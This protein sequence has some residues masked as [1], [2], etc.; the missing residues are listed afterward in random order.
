MKRFAAL[1][2][3][4]ESTP[5]TGEKTAA[6][7]EYFR[8]APEP[9]RVWTIA[10]LSGRRPKRAVNAT[11]LRLWAAQAANVPLWLFEESYAVAGDL[12][13]TIAH[14]LPPAT[15]T[16]AP[17]LE[18]KVRALIALTGRAE[19]ERR[20]FVL[21]AWRTLGSDERFLFNKLLTGGFRM[22]VSRGLMTRAL[23]QATGVDNAVMAHRL[24]GD[25]DPAHTLFGDLTQDGG[26][27]TAARPYPFALASPLES[28]PD[29]LGEPDEYLAEWKWDGIRGQ[30]IARTGAFAIWS[31]GEDLITDRFPEFAPL[32][33]HLPPGTVLDGEIVAW[34]GTAP[35]PFADLQK[36]IGR[37][38]VPRKLLAE[39]P[40][41]F[42]AY[43]L[44]ED[45]G[46]DLRDAPLSHRRTRL[47]AV[48]T[49][50]PPG[51]P[52]SASPV[53]TGDWTQLANLRASA[54]AQMAEGLMLKRLAAPY[55]TGRK[56]GDWWKWKLDPFTVDAV[57][58]YAQ[59]GH[60]R[61]A[62]LFSDFTFALRD[63]NDLVP[64]TK[65][66][67]G[68]TDAEFAE[69]TRWVGK[70]TL[71][72]FGPVRRVTP[73]LV[74]EIGFEGIQASPRHKSGIALRFPRI[75]RWRRDKGVAEIDTLDGL[76]DLLRQVSEAGALPAEGLKTGALPPD[77]QDI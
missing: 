64:F 68:L 7:T 11:E 36:R 76:R 23:A 12:A 60:G 22:G 15:T 21:A 73:E 71:E 13:E 63:G 32:Q 77:P 1:F 69:I 50:L 5:K 2:T 30:I 74:F 4:L 57:M 20:E 47:E 62:N 9:D 18:S 59:S 44:L 6:L 65:A 17:S 24:M 58:I 52:L 37:K 67:S 53:T 26:A 43:D 14:L 35:L 38:T 72:R 39:A 31:R 10:L 75:L 28:G 3:A 54:R 19:T 66:Y 48:L 45:G 8:T 16:A 40:A 46:T 41:Y 27:E 49:A 51:L 25:W 42:L 33:D 34:G 55:H 56:R 70:H 61:R 29:S